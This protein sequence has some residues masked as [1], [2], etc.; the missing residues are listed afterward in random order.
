MSLPATVFSATLRA[1][2]SLSANSGATFASGALMI[3]GISSTL[4][5]MM[6]TGMEALSPRG[7]SAMTVTM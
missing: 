4:V 3:S 6:V 1:P 7:S 2:S 5:T